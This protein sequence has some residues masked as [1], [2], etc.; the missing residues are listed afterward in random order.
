MKRAIFVLAVVIFV[1]GTIFLLW[2]LLSPQRAGLAVESSP[3]ATVYLN[4][5][6]VGKTPYQN[7]HLRPGNWQIKLVVDNKQW[8]W[9]RTL[10]IP[11]DTRV[12][13]HREFRDPL[14]Q[15]RVV[16]LLPTREKDKA[17]CF[18]TSLPPKA[19]VTIDG[20][21]KG[22]TPLSLKDIGSGGHHF[23]FSLPQRPNQELE[24]QAVA[25][26]RLVA[27][28]D[29]GPAKTASATPTPAPEAGP[30]VKIKETPT[31]WLRV[32]EKPTRASPEVAK[33]TPGKKYPYRDEKNGW[34][35]IEYQPGK[36]GW[37]SGRYATKVD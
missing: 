34:L 29:F 9:E 20:E 6:A 18:L 16:Y 25:G 24:L 1:A 5:R 4:G 35:E 31:G 2:H 19:S 17:G 26:Y 3:A 10:S 21:M 14:S 30:E 15:G 23:V 12:L 28:V 22:F 13:V 8:T 27:E 36:T 37:V 32:R 7:N 33:V 11:A